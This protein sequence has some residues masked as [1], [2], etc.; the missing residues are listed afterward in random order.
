MS[1]YAPT[2][3]AALPFDDPLRRTQSHRVLKSQPSNPLAPRYLER[4]PATERSILPPPLQMNARPPEPAAFLTMDLEVAKASPT[5][6]EAVGVASR[7][8]YG[9]RLPEIVSQN[10]R[11][12]ILALQRALQDEQSRKEPNYLPPIFGRDQAAQIMEALSFDTNSI[13]RFSLERQD[14]ITFIS[15][16][17]QPRMFPVRVGLAKEDSTYFV[18]LL[19]NV[20]PR[21]LSQPSP[22]P[23]ARD[24]AY[25]YQPQTFPQST[26]ILGV[27]DPGQHQ[28]GDDRWR[29]T[30]T[31][32]RPQPSSLTTAGPNASLSSGSGYSTPLDV[33]SDHPSYQIPRSE[34]SAVGAAQAAFQLPPIRSRPPPSSSPSG[35]RTSRVAIGGLIDSPEPSK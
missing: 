13:S 21:A 25:S 12:R 18:V 23:H 2:S 35:N 32:S 30:H 7:D 15:I 11:D 1:L 28:A 27:N 9:R 10:E 20:Q 5:F 26:P 8:I 24:V 34:L 19:L 6:L 29:H 22:S 4:G 16:D 33:R 3:A 17:G 14:L 31:A